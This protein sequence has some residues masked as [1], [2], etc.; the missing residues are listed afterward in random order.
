MRKKWGSVGFV[1]LLPH[2]IRCLTLKVR[3]LSRIWMSSTNDRK[4]RVK[5]SSILIDRLHRLRG[6]MIQPHVR[7]LIQMSER[8]CVESLRG[9]FMPVW[10]FLAL[11]WRLCR[12]NNIVWCW[13]LPQSKPTCHR[14]M[15]SAHVMRNLEASSIRPPV[16]PLGRF[17]YH[18]LAGTGV[19]SPY[20]AMV[21]HII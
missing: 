7:H 10:L 20:T 5:R 17:A 8:F 1:V 3:T 16:R 9:F 15:S 18:K 21:K 13:W 12:S 4:E 14:L 19:S 11:L 2:G 6:V